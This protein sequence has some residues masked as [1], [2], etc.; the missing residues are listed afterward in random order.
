[1][2]KKD[3][4]ERDSA[5]FE[6]GQTVYDEQGRSYEYDGLYGEQHLVAELGIST[7]FD[8]DAEHVEEELTGRMLL[9]DDVKASLPEV[10]IPPYMQVDIDRAEKRIGMLREQEGK[11]SKEVQA[12]NKDKRELTERISRVSKKFPSV[13]YML[14]FMEGKDLYVAHWRDYGY[15]EIDKL[16]ELKGDY[17][18]R[19]VSIQ[20][21]CR[22]SKWVQCYDWMLHE[23][24]DDSG[25]KRPC[26]VGASLEEVLKRTNECVVKMLN[27]GLKPDVRVLQGM[28]D[29]GVDVPECEIVRV[30]EK[31]KEQEER[32]KANATRELQ[33]VK[34]SAKDLG[35]NLVKEG[36]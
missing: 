19:M 5:V 9:L 3:L 23:Y 7:Y 14:D 34:R 17:G 22:E 4:A 15:F 35:Y 11:L 16:S 10:R 24:S 21:E 12:M 20:T 26:V 29:A 27:M 33:R 25:N 30:K 32:Q 2:S 8:G 18:L 1:M 31:A 6:K 13:G 28:M 36:E